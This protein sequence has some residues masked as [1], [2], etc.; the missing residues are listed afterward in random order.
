MGTITSE[1][2]FSA[3]PEF[4]GS[5][6]PS[7]NQKITFDLTLQSEIDAVDGGRFILEG[8]D[9]FG[10][11]VKIFQDLHPAPSVETQTYNIRL[12]EKY[13]KP[14]HGPDITSNNF[15]TLLDNL[16]SVKIQV[17]PSTLDNV[18]LE[19]A[20]LRNFG[21]KSSQNEVANWIEVCQ[22]NKYEGNSLDICAEGFTRAHKSDY[23][24]LVVKDAFDDCVECDCNQ[25]SLYACEPNSGVCA[26]DHN[27]AGD[28]CQTCADGFYG[29]AQG[30]K[31]SDCKACPCPDG[32]ACH[33][34]DIVEGAG[35]PIGK[36]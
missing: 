29:N 10:D 30:G 24:E 21:E 19:T 14:E 9:E 32:T 25:H 13:L 26:C 28:H 11:K 15:I 12:H 3:S 20:E 4:T 7:Y 17:G 22:E 27:T 18:K 34:I 6:R 8:T 23:A 35:N 5:Q 16:E 2:G 33:L 31:K 1:A 36:S